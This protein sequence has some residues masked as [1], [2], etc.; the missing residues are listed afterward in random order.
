MGGITEA[1]KKV[2]G[3]VAAMRY[4]CGLHRDWRTRYLGRRY[5]EGGYLRCGDVE[6]FCDFRDLVCAWYDGL[7]S[8]L[9]KDLEILRAL[10]MQQA[11]RGNMLLDTG[12]HYA[13]ST[14]SLKHCARRNGILEA[15]VV[16]MEP[17]RRHFA[18][19]Q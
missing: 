18:C 10:L 1:L 9:A 3:L 2:P 12:A 17:D 7:S 13:F 6:I 11:G 15:R 5:R 8:N 4:G 16:A 19:L 14:A